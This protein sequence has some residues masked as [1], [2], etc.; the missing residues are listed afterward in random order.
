MSLVTRALSPLFALALVTALSVAQTTPPPDDLRARADAKAKEIGEVLQ[1]T[2]ASDPKTIELLEKLLN[3]LKEIRRLLEEQAAA[4]KPAPKPAEPAYPKTTF[5][6]YYQF[7]YQNNDAIGSSGYDAFRFRRIRPQ[8]E[9]EINPRVKALLAFE[10]ASGTNQLG[11]ELRDLKITYDVS[12]TQELI[13]GQFRPQ[14]GFDLPRSSGA[15]EF[16]ERSLYNRSLFSGERFRGVEFAQTAGRFVGRVGGYNSL[17][18]GDP[19]Q[20]SLPPGP[21]NRLAVAVSGQYNTG[22]VSLEIGTLVG[23]RAEFQARAG[24]PILPTVKREIAFGDI[25]WRI[26]RGAVLRG[27]FLAGRDRIPNYAVNNGA[28]T[29][30]RAFQLL[31]SYDFTRLDQIALRWE[32]FD[33]DL[34]STGDA[35]NG[36]GIAYRRMLSEGTSLHFAYESFVDGTRASIGQQRTALTTVRYQVRF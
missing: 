12:P 26:A 7:L 5:G 33:R 27:E 25:E 29:R 24:A 20:S 28:G 23:D 3:E 15:R 13:A 31:G 10:L 36:Y 2:Q 34:A 30:F 16:P 32:Q 17:T 19:E 35:M 1:R 6:G 11:V 9:T 22:P 8:I 21:G 14:I 18:V 4:P